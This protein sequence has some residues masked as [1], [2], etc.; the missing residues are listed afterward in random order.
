MLIPCSRA[1]AVFT[2][3]GVRLEWSAPGFMVW[4]EHGGT[5]VLRV[6]EAAVTAVA[7]EESESGILLEIPLAPREALIGRLEEFAAQQQ[8][9]LAPAPGP[10]AD[11]GVLAACHL[12]GQNLF[13]FVEGPALVAKK[14]GDCLA[15]A[16]T[17]AFKARRVVCQDTDLVIHLSRPAMARLVAFVLRQAR[18]EP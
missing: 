3:P 7:P 9:P 16:V 4:D 14:S 1:Q 6:E 11:A 5:Y 18:G 12:P 15:I 10:D 13:I 8:L 2:A 17:G